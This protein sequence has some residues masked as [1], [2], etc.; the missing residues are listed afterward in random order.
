MPLGLDVLHQMGLREQ[1]RS[2][3]GDAFECWEIYLD[4]RLT[5]KIDEPTTE[6]GDFAF[7]VASP[8]ALME[9]LVGEA[10]RHV[11]FSFRPGTSVRGLLHERERVAGVL[12]STPAGEEEVAGDLVIGADGRSSVVRTRSGLA[13]VG[14]GQPGATLQEH[15]FL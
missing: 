2:V 13:L 1:L 5:M 15:R 8:G 4:G 7:R 3:P 10:S 14:T 12:V 9:L 6:L 11:G